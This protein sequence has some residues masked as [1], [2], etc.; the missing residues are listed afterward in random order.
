[1]SFNLFDLTRAA[2]TP[3]VIGKLAGIIGE[4]PAT[5]QKA[6]DLIVPSLAG[7]A[8]HQASTPSGA[9][10]LLN[11]LSPGKL[12]TSILGNLSGLLAGGA[13]TTG[14][15]DMGGTLLRGMLGSN[16]GGVASAIA[17]AAGIPA[18]A[19]SSLLSLLA[20]VVFGFIAKHV[21]ANGLS[22]SGLASLLSANRETIQRLAPPGLASALGVSNLS[23]MCGPA[24]G[25]YVA[26]KVEERH[27]GIPMWA[28]A[29]PLIAL[30]GGIPLYRSCSAP[31]GP[32]MVSINLPCGK[33][34]RVLDGS[35]NFMLANFLL[36]GTESDLPKRLVFDNLNFDSGN[37][38]LTPESE[39][40]VANLIEIMKCY[41]NM[42][43]TL[44]GHTDSTGS[45]EANKTLSLARANLVRDRLVSGGIDAAR[46][47]TD[48]WGQDRPIASNDTE[49][50][51]ARNRRTECI[52]TRMK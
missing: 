26:P 5:T 48:G 29:I 45:A 46:L 35:F 44:E 18:S 13:A 23:S 6:A 16:L 31:A 12:D 39:P 10:N 49:E 47:S 24:P 3:E 25:A 30:L 51:R 40:T 1:M 34:I 7:I 22:A 43:I 4:T 2:L 50:G 33:A 38:R 14:L 27:S 15:M 21:T 41:P 9:N 19:A 32:K 52:V 20:P 17:S 42:T 37:T 28:W 11:L 8:C 36:S